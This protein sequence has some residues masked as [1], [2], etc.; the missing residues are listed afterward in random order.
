[1]I[2]HTEVTVVINNSI[3]HS[4]SW[5]NSANG[6]GLQIHQPNRVTSARG[7]RKMPGIP[8][9]IFTKGCTSWNAG[10]GGSSAEQLILAFVKGWGSQSSPPLLPLG[11]CRDVKDPQQNIYQNHN[12]HGTKLRGIPSRIPY[13]TKLRGVPSR[14][15]L[16][17]RS[18]QSPPPLLP[19][20]GCSDESRRPVWGSKYCPAS[21]GYINGERTLPT[22]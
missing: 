20:G 15:P 1:M 17:G 14:I 6:V 4:I 13:Q 19:L 8:S 22:L 3:F 18:S 7:K 10:G 5:T 2:L 16:K 12:V 11:G 21:S 9:G